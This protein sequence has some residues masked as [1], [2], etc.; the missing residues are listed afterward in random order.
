MSVLLL[1]ATIN[2][3]YFGNV[4]TLIKDY[5]E[6]KQ[7]YL[8]TL[9]R[10]ISESNFDKIVFAENS[11]ESLDEESLKKLAESYGKKL[12]FLSLPGDKELMKKQGKSYGEAKIIH[13]A[14]TTSALIQKEEAIY[15][16][17]GRVYVE[18]I[19]KLINEQV[20][21]NF[22]AHNFKSWVLTSFFKIRKDDFLL[23]FENTPELSND[24]TPDYE[25]CIEHVY[26]ET[27]KT[28]NHP[29]YAFPTYPDLRG[30][31]SGSN[32]PYTKS[33][34]AL[35]LRN[36]LTKI[37]WYVFDPKPRKIYKLIE[38]AL[39]IKRKLR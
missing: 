23:F 35:F 13:D 9:K 39:R 28:V 27:L 6:R 11:N 24:N 34:R 32:T 7:Q 22:V 2:S 16:V 25:W 37:N 21:N 8:V 26:Y 12:E 20:E 10:Y 15:K 14:F 30:I 33:K 17:T 29:V 38:I 18:N 4:G 5:D 36:L 31:N 1:T 19:N 3:A